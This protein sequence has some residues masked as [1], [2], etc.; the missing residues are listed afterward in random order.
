[1]HVAIDD[2]ATPIWGLPA[3]KALCFLLASLHILYLLFLTLAV[4]YAYI[5]TL[6][7]PAG[8]AYIATPN[9]PLSGPW[10]PV[11]APDHPEDHWT[12]SAAITLGYVHVGLKNKTSGTLRFASVDNDRVAQQMCALGHG[13]HAWNHLVDV[14]RQVDDVRL[15]KWHYPLVLALAAGL[16]VVVL[17]GLAAVFMATSIKAHQH[18]AHTYRRVS[19]LL[20][21]QLFGWLV[22]FVGS[23]VF[24]GAFCARFLA[25][26]RQLTASDV[27]DLDPW[28]HKWKLLSAAH[29][30]PVRGVELGGIFLGLAYFAGLLCVAALL[31]QLRQLFHERRRHTHQSYAANVE[32]LV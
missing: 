30:G 25:L 9:P 8:M 14:F 21:L 12:L 2:K 27:Y 16:A 22:T 10:Y 23:A 1:M 29:D 15:A 11:L 20:G 24:Y 18:K 3:P 5:Y 32:R 17:W 19:Q 13:C 7:T 28:A 6:A 31:V 26:L 4:T